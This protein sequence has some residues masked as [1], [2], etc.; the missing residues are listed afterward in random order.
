MLHKSTKSEPEGVEEIVLVSVLLWLLD[1][2]GGFLP[3]VWG[4]PG[5]HVDNQGDQDKH[6][7]CV[8]VDLKK[9]TNDLTIVTAL[10]TH[11]CGKWI[12]EGEH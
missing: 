5:Q 10:K 2:V 4:E 9:N 8:D 12:Q 3:L 1:A 6:Q 7:E 11:I